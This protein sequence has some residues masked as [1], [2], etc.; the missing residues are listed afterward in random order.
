MALPPPHPLEESR[1]VA[2]GGPGPS[3]RDCDSQTVAAAR[4]GD[5]SA[6]DDLSRAVWPQIRRIA[7]AITGNP[8]LADDVAQDAMLRVLRALPRFDLSRPLG[9]WVRTI[10]RNAA[11]NARAR[12]DH[13]AEPTTDVGTRPDLERAM[14]L[15]AAARSALTAFSGLT[16]R[17][18]ELIELCD[19][20]GLTPAE[21]AEELGIAGGTARA[22]LH[23]A[24]HALR[25]RLLADRPDLLDLLRDA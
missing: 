3:L 2:V 13:P 25:V 22:T 10:A 15:D 21:A 9:P 4:E 5:R 8:V 20:Q 7:L 18:R 6:V 1:P 19:H 11:R 23:A 12:T 16:E 14:D 24:R 17:Q